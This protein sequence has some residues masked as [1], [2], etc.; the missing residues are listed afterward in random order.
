MTA[1][2]ARLFSGQF[3]SSTP[4]HPGREEAVAADSCAGTLSLVF[5][6]ILL[7]GAAAGILYLVFQP[8]LPKGRRNTTVLNVVL[9][10]QTEDAN[11]LITSLQQQQ[12]Q[13]GIIPLNLRVIQPVR[14]CLA[15]SS[16]WR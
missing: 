4:N 13:T 15:S 11:T 5:L 2:T 10:G 1:T 8:E 6:L 7:V 9:S 14:I 12:Q 3:R 16:S